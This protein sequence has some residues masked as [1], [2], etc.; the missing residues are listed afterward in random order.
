MYKDAIGEVECSAACTAAIKS[1]LVTCA[2]LKIPAAP[3]G[4]IV[5]FNELL[6]LAGTFCKG[7]FS[8][9]G[10]ATVGAWPL[11][12]TAISLCAGRALLALLP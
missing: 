1:A 2:E 8:L 12:A 11:A 3:G 9:S 7:H 6:D 4:V 10:A 5:S